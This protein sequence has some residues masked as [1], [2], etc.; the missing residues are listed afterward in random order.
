MLR[1][2]DIHMKRGSALLEFVLTMPFALILLFITLDTGK[3][4]FVRVSLQSAAAT[5]AANGAR[6]GYIGTVN[7]T[8]CSVNSAL[9]IVK[10][11]CKAAPTESMGAENSE[12]TV[13]M[14]DV[15]GGE[16]NSAQ[17]CTAKHPYVTVTAE[18]TLKG[19][20]TPSISVWGNSALSL[21]GK[22]TVVS[23]AYCEVYRE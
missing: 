3:A 12:I 14:S 4:V 21:F 18:T 19:M 6:S 1:S 16:D 9:D 2:A 23:T 22:L 17:W 13:R 7:S 8:T 11:F 5:A 20:L 10:S 15:N